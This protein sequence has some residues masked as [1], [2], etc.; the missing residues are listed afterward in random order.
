MKVGGGRGINVGLVGG[1]VFVGGEKKVASLVHHSDLAECLMIQWV[2]QGFA[3]DVQNCF[4]KLSGT[5]VC[6]TVQNFS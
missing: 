6:K 4:W 1:S 3:L 2:V 5:K